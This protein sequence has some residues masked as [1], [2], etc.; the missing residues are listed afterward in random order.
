M[1]Q[2]IAD[3]FLVHSFQSLLAELATTAANRIRPT[4]VKGSRLEGCTLI[5]VP[6]PLQRRAFQLLDVSR[7]LGYGWSAPVREVLGQGVA[8]TSS[9]GTTLLGLAARAQ[10]RSHNWREVPSE[11]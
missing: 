8:A 3:R 9:G 7:C 11:P 10:A 5:T 1:L 2:R 6:T 4:D